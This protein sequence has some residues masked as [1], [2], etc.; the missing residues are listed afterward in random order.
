MDFRDI[1]RIGMHE[2][3][4]GLHKVLTGLT[5]AERRFQ[6]NPAANHIDFTLWHMARNEDETFHLIS[7]IDQ[8]WVRDR[9]YEKLGLGRDDD[10]CGF[11][12]E[13]VLSMPSFDLDDCLHYY[14]NVRAEALALLEG[15]VGDDLD[16]SPVGLADPTVTTIG[17]LLSHLLVEQS[18]H[19][20]QVA[21][22]RGLQRGL[23]YTTSWNNPDTPL[24]PS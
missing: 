19:L 18:Q 20:G 22:L 21:Y 4:D 24:P 8:L 9:W 14:A 15:L 17:R 2:Y 23:E 11:T 5:S 13:Q 1:I 3:L 16:R 7:G 6:P 12:P 10:G